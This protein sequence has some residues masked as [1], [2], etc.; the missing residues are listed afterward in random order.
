MK[1]R[2]A[3]EVAD[4][5]RGNRIGQFVAE[6]MA[7]QADVTP[8]DMNDVAR[9]MAYSRDTMFAEGFEAGFRAVARPLVEAT[10]ESFT[11]AAFYDATGR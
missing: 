7:S 10:G 3:A 9:K 4:F 6:A 1:P 11:H 5:D 2:N 8:E